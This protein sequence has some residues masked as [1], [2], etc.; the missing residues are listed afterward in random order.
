MHYSKYR[1]LVLYT[2]LI[3][4]L[5]LFWYELFH[6]LC[7]DPRKMFECTLFKLGREFC[8]RDVLHSGPERDQFVFW[9]I[10]RN[11]RGGGSKVVPPWVGCNLPSR[12]KHFSQHRAAAISSWSRALQAR[13]ASCFV[14]RFL[15]EIGRDR[16]RFFALRGGQDLVGSLYRPRQ[17][18]WAWWRGLCKPET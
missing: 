4:R 18:L 11:N 13:I 6:K 7:R 1:N 14:F 2:A 9:W 10:G 17:C 8:S 16:E 5:K 15:T 3:L 12:S